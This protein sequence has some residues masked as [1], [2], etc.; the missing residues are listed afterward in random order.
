MLQNAEATLVETLPRDIKAIEPLSLD[1]RLIQLAQLV[2][3]GKKTSD[4]A[5]QLGMSEGWVRTNKKNTQVAKLVTALQEEALDTAKKHIINNTTKA[6]EK[7]TTLI[8]SLDER[9]AFA[10]SKDI[11]NRGG[12]KTEE[13]THQSGPGVV[14][15]FSNV[16]MD[17]LKLMVMNKVKA[18]N[19]KD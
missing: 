17:E 8:D 5:S 6:A 1:D 13:E 4:I 11:L 15:N 19:S 3:L 7:L 12:I 16:S 9:V 2:A 14:I 18:V 10:A